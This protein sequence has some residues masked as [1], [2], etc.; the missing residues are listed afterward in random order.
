[1]EQKTIETARGQ[2]FRIAWDGISTIDGL[3][4]IAI[5]DADMDTVHETFKNP[6][7]TQTLTRTW[8]GVDSVYSGYTAYRGFT[9]SVTGEIIVALGAE[10]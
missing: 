3:L 9:K 5:L 4:R 2:V 7:E 6:E 10:D 8:D 1:M